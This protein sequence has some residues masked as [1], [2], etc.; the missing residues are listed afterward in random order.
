VSGR[1][2]SLREQA[3]RAIRAAIASGEIAPGEIHSAPEL[4]RR[5]GIS[6]TPVRE[7]MLS[8]LGAGVVE[9]VPNRGFRVARLT[10]RELDEVLELR[11]LVEAPLLG[12]LAGTVGAL[13][14]DSAAE[15]RRLAA[16]VSATAAPAAFAERE[17]ALH[18]RLEALCENE[19]AR[20][21]LAQ[22]RGYATLHRLG[23]RAAERH[24]AELAA[25][26]RLLVDAIL[27]GSREA[28][29]RAVRDHLAALRRAWSDVLSSQSRD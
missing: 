2:A 18:E 28:A 14:P 7:A 11:E 5:L 4:G 3:T 15:L 24:G 29:E 20:E 12:R 17:A 25:A 6:A 10:Q 21:L 19:A 1:G 27:S 22:L 26:Q 16:A 23:V 13:G 9:A 8:L